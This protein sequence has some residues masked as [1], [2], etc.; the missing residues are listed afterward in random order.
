M[1]SD[2]CFQRLFLPP[3][4]QILTDAQLSPEEVDHWRSI[5]RA[6]CLH[7]L[8]PDG[9]H[10]EDESIEIGRKEGS[11]AESTHSDIY[12]AAGLFVKPKSILN[13]VA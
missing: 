4:K 13:M 11:P 7:M 12:E 3:P 8:S 6:D 10:A 5:I 1:S 9:G 2:E